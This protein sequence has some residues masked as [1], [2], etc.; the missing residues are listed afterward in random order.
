MSTTDWDD[1]Y[2]A[3]AYLVLNDGV[4]ELPA[5][6]VALAVNNSAKRTHRSPLIELMEMSDLDIDLKTFTRLYAQATKN[7][8]VDLAVPT[9]ETD[10]EPI[11][12]GNLELF[13]GNQCI[14]VSIDGRRV[15][16]AATPS[17]QLRSVV[18]RA[19]TDTAQPTIAVGH[20]P[21][22][23]AR[24]LRVENEAVLTG[25][26]DD[27]DDPEPVKKADPI[28]R[29]AFEDTGNV[30]FVRDTID[31]AAAQGAS[32]L[33]MSLDEAGRLV[34]RM[35]IDGKL[36]A[37]VTP[38][39]AGKK[40]IQSAITHA[41]A[42]IGRQN[43]PQSN[44]FE[45]QP[46]GGARL[47]IRSELTPT[48]HG[49]ELTWRLLDATKAMIRLDDM[50]L[51]PEATETLK[52]VMS[53]SSGMLVTTGPTG[54]G[55]STTMYALLQERLGRNEKIITIEHPVE[56]QMAGIT[57]VE[58]TEAGKGVSWMSAIKS[59]LRADPD[60]IL[61]GEMRDNA[62]AQTAV[63]AAMT[64][65]L[66]LSTLHT[67]SALGVF[68]RMIDLGV[69]KFLAGDQ[70]RAAIGQR[71]VRRLHRDCARVETLDARTVEMLEAAGIKDV[72]EA[73]MPGGCDICGRT[74]F[75]GRTALMELL[76]TDNS[77]HDAIRHANGSEVAIR[78]AANEDNYIPFHVDAKR[79][80]TSGITSPRE[81]L[82][83]LTVQRAGIW[84][85]AAR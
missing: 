55:K 78:E 84:R 69:D 57:Q 37:M 5:K 11:S 66:V 24:L 46:L 6:Y 29:V 42:D 82:P 7:E 41:G 67:T 25:H 38:K 56:Y 15:L 49:P 43:E 65:H 74:G 35:R 40:L 33:H 20:L 77:I 12:K 1:V 18:R 73:S 59:S 9:V 47:D 81:V 4:E 16:V 61:I 48:I 28:A 83:L 52:Q 64:G 8:F 54:S 51:A 19:Y 36:R 26:F 27:I 72:T 10:V 14:P 79:L 68:A 2:S 45:H 60:V 76:V 39:S 3:L 22:I 53:K 32:D 75:K 80:V 44:K 58:I 23:Q 71:I 62:T 31:K 17:R 34:I 63:Q 50:G 21:E 30:S 70:I 13:Q 85:P